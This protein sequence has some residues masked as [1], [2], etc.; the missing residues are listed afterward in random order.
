MK[1]ATFFTIITFFTLSGGFFCQTPPPKKSELKI[2]ETQGGGFNLEKISFCADRKCEESVPGFQVKLKRKKVLLIYL[3]L[4]H[5]GDMNVITWLKEGR[6]SKLNVVV[7][8]TTGDVLA[9][10]PVNYT[11]IRYKIIQEIEF[12]AVPFSGSEIPSGKVNGSEYATDD[13]GK[14]SKVLDL[15]KQILEPYQSVTK[16]VEYKD[17]DIIPQAIELE[18]PEGASWEIDAFIYLELQLTTKTISGGE[19]R[20]IEPGKKVEIESI[21]QTWGGLNTPPF[22]FK[23]TR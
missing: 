19:D 1:T 23:I 8:S 9:R 6:F 17:K 10:V 5:T 11:A 14:S 12:D 4:R 21:S 15:T 13:N 3:D 18:L 16:K 20:E 22:S 7:K 2:S